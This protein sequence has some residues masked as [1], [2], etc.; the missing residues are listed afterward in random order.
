[1]ARAK[2]QELDN[3]ESAI[4]IREK[5]LQKQIE[6]DSRALVEREHKLAQ[7]I[8][9]ANSELEKDKQKFLEKTDVIVY[10]SSKI[11]GWD[12]ITSAL[13]SATL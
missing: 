7:S 10:Y 11:C 2:Q 6:R 5:Q 1:M 8:D 13:L 3:R 12:Y 9:A 4:I